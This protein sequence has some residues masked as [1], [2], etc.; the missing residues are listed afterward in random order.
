MDTKYHDVYAQIGLNI[1][2]Y[3][4]KL[5]FTQMQL[6]EKTSLSRNHIQKIETATAIPSLPALLSIAEA[7]HVQPA[8]LFEIR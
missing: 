8:K 5:W 6:A 1:L 7:L 2:H 4:K 3:R